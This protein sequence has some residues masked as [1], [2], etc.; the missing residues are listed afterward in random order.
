MNHWKILISATLVIAVAIG[1]GRFGYTPMLPIMIKQ[2]GLSVAIGGY[3]AS[4]N[5]LGYTIGA[6]T[7]LFWKGK[8]LDDPLCRG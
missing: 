7:P 3:I 5:F 2:A 8:G 4:A 6:L 1:F